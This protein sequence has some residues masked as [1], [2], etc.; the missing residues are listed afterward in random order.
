MLFTRPVHIHPHGI[1]LLSNNY[2]VKPPWGWSALCKENSW[3]RW[4]CPFC[5]F[6]F[7]LKK[8]LEPGLQ[9][10]PLNT[11]LIIFTHYFP[12][13]W[14][15][16]LL[17]FFLIFINFFCSFRGFAVIPANQLPSSTPSL[18]PQTHIMTTRSSRGAT[19]HMIKDVQTQ[20]PHPPTKKK[21]HTQNTAYVTRQ[22]TIC[23]WYNRLFC[24]WKG[25]YRD[26]LTVSFIRR[27]NLR[28]DRLRDMCQ[29][30]SSCNISWEYSFKK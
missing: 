14:F 2:G 28:P 4:N 30:H 20:P 12:S 3:N 23:L 27:C 7:F 29:L 18:P 11:L 5:C 13:L 9:P 26:T 19:D 17:F 6:F 22:I 10:P 21:Q 16:L 15:F 1:F 25:G 8:Q 24:T